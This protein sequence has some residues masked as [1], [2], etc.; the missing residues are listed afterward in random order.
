MA[1]A[2]PLFLR[3]E[4]YPFPWKELTERQQSA[5]EKIAQ[6]LLEASQGVK[7]QGDRA[8]RTLDFNRRSQLA[9]ID[10]DR[11][12]GKTSVLLSVR[13]LI[14]GDVAIA[15]LPDAVRRLL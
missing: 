13:N 10:G 6:L 9:F 2:Y 11:G 7:P 8:P 4:A 5:V 15:D 1:S 3:R 14:E 12:M